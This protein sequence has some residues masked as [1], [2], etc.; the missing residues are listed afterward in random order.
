[1]KKYGIFLEVWNGRAV[2]VWCNVGKNGLPNEPY[3]SWDSADIALRCY[4][5]M[6]PNGQYSIKEIPK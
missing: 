2:N 1:M 4:S 5:R 3:K 6:Y